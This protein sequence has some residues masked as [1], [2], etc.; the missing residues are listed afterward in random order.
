[1][2][3]LGS[4]TISRFGPFTK[5]QTFKF[6]SKPGLYFM[7]GINKVAP[8]LD[9]NG[10][11]KTS[12]WAALFWLFYGKSPRGL[13]AGDVANWT[14]GKGAAV[15]LM[16]YRGSAAHVL[17]RT[18]SPNSWTLW[19][20]PSQQTI[21]LTKDDTNEVMSWLR[22]ESAPFLN[23]ILMAQREPMFLDMKADLKTAIFSEVMGLDMWLDCSSRASKKASAQDMIIRSIE[24][25][26]SELQGQLTSSK[27]EDKD[28]GTT[29]DD[30]EVNRMKR[31]LEVESIYKEQLAKEDK[32]LYYIE[33]CKTKVEQAAKVHEVAASDV[34][35]YGK[36]IDKC[37]I[38]LTEAQKA[39]SVA[40]HQS[41]VLIKRIEFLREHD[42]CPQC[43]QDLSDELRAKKVHTSTAEAA[44]AN[45][46]EKQCFAKM[47]DAERALA[48]HLVL[49]DK[50]ERKARDAQH[51]L[52][53]AEANLR[54]A[55]RNHQLLQKRLDELE[56]QFASVEK[57]ENPYAVLKA[58][59]KQDRKGVQELIKQTVDEL[60]DAKA[61]WARLTTWVKAFKE[62]RLQQ[63]SEALQQLEIEVNSCVM[64]L[65][66]VDWELKFAVDREAKN[67]NIQ[68]G[69][70]VH[71]LSPHNPN[72]VPWEAWSGG[73]AQRLK[74]ATQMG[75]ANLIRERTGTQLNIEA[76]DESTSGLSPQ[77]ITD[78][79]HC[80]KQRATDEQRVI[81]IVDHNMFDFGGFDGTVTV[82]KSGHGSRVA[83]T[84]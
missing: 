71:V 49:L 39:L 65:G 73:E 22:L 68:R 15:E 17:K 40:E 79:L 29:H 38:D 37:R 19:D 13:K 7:K 18:W 54:D 63:I 25:K 26:L 41:D 43:D 56:E 33:E 75:L 81:F 42:H 51:Q 69:F 62:I 47:K 14:E 64:A 59:A 78:L 44:K 50:R 53:D 24:R 9:G 6:P 84:Y 74:L 2:I 28:L 76:W 57:E 32:S 11:G 52:R 36:M 27:T 5:E 55:Q 1:M 21:D 48:E 45:K 77:G 46:V 70:T 10:S 8:R 83:S 4:L 20:E 80:L 67:G 3:Q 66:L 23:C 30:W 60:D 35:G 31:L 16:F 12:L 82:T 58:K 61:Q 72:P 34:S